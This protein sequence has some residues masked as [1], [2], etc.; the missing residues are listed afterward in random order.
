LE[1]RDLV[2]KPKLNN[3]TFPLTISIVGISVTINIGLTNIL[4]KLVEKDKKLFS[5]PDVVIPIPYINQN[6]V[7]HDYSLEYAD[8]CI[9][10]G[11]DLLS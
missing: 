6:I 2:L 9:I 1:N 11:F 5:L 7:P 8:N 4:R 3:V 10:I